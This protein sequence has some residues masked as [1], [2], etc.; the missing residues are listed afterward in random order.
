MGGHVAVRSRP[1]HGATFALLLPA[2]ALRLERPADGADAVL[3][4]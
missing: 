3:A 4:P 1:G 2:A